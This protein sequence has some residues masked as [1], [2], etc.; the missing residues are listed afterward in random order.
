ML[1]S[2]KGPGWSIERLVRRGGCLQLLSERGDGWVFPSSE[3]GEQACSRNLA[4]DWW[5]RAAALAKLPK[6]ERYGWHS[7][8]R[9][10]ATAMRDESPRDMID[11]GGWASYDTPLKCYIRP[12]LEAQRGAFAKR[13]ELRALVDVTPILAEATG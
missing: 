10:W 4:R 13:R 7:L 2:W 3:G 6:G 12:D 8:R 11:L 1:G 5:E 9:G